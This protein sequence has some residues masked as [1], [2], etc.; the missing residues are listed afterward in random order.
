MSS[1]SI[2]KH[3]QKYTPKRPYGIGNP[4]HWNI[5]ESDNPYTKMKKNEVNPGDTIT[6]DSYNQKGM[7]KYEVIIN[8]NGK[9]DLKM[10]DSYDMYMDRLDN[11]SMSGGKK[12]NKKNRTRRHKK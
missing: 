12:R 9:K 11:E 7:K 8:K 4:K 10:I 1:K 6:I 3:T 2:R 5:S